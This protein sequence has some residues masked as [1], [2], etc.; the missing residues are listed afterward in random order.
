MDIDCRAKKRY[1]KV[2]MSPGASATLAL[3]AGMSR[4]EVA[5]T[6]AD[7]KGVIGWVVG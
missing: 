3:V 7:G 6:G 1:L 2:S 5:P 4:A